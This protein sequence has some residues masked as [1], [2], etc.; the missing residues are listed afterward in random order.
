MGT[1]FLGYKWGIFGVP[2]LPWLTANFFLASKYKKA[3]TPKIEFKILNTRS[4]VDLY[5]RFLQLK[6]TIS[7]NFLLAAAAG[8]GRTPR[9]G[10]GYGRSWVGGGRTHVGRET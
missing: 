7:H 9:R 4:Y 3:K 5:L 10:V 2:Y 8:G 1:P 6:K